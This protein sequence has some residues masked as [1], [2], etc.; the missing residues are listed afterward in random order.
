MEG[1]IDKTASYAIYHALR[2]ERRAKVAMIAAAAASGMS[3]VALL[4]A[5]FWQGKIQI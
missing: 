5:F 1:N 3:L 2:A 4:L